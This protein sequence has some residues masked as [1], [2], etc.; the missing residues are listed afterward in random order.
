[1][2]KKRVLVSYGVD[3]DAVAGWLGSYGGEDSSNDISRGLWAGHIGT[4][5]LLK[6]FSKYN[7][8]ATFFIPG[9]SLETFP[10]ECAMVRDAGHEIGLHGYTHENPS[11]MTLEQQRDILDKTYHM[12]YD[13]TGKPPRGIVA[14]WWETSKEMADLLL[15]YGIE[16]DHSMSHHDCQMYWLRTGD[17]WTKIDYSQKAETWMKP[18]VR[19]QDTGLVEIPGNWY[20]DDLPPMM[21]IKS[22]P[23][24]HG[25]VNPKDVEDLWKDHFDYFYREY[26]EFVFP[27]TIHPDVS[28]RPHVLLMHERII[29]YINKHEGVEWVTFEQ[30]CDDFKSKNKPP[31]GARMPSAPMP[32]RK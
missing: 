23:N 3:I 15:S 22:A 27:M 20:I 29:E 28:G 32:A 19:G 12:L 6:L 13:F 26:D 18:L 31:E 8:K 30:M 4:T 1:M 7:I 9:H 24:S 10:E 5:R 11:D 17:T 2:G 14:P 16:Y 25:W 21:F